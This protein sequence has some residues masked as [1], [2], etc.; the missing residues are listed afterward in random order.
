MIYGVHNF[1]TVEDCLCCTS[2]AGYNITL[3]DLVNKVDFILSIKFH[4]SA[5]IWKL[6]YTE[7]I[8]EKLRKNRNVVVFP[9]ENA[10]LLCRISGVY[11]CIITRAK[12]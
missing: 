2:I 10:S 8:L 1:S 12:Q 11:C 9:S 5:H 3:M 6:V 7:R 4:R